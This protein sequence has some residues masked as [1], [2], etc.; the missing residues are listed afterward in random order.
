MAQCRPLPAGAGAAAAWARVYYEHPLATEA[1]TA[2]RDRGAEAHLADHTA[3][4]ER[5]GPRPR[6]HG[7]L[8]AVRSD[9]ILVSMPM[10][11][12]GRSLR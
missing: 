10:V 8:R 5:L 6:Q 2:A 1:V 7:D 4:A 12:L 3:G 9:I 11:L